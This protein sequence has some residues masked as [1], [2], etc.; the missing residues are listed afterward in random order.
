MK[1]GKGKDR[2]EDEGGV[3]RTM[4]RSSEVKRRTEIH[5]GNEGPGVDE[6]TAPGR[7]TDKEGTVG[8]LQNSVMPTLGF[9]SRCRKV[10]ES[11]SGRVSLPLL[12]DDHFPRGPPRTIGVSRS[13]G[14]VRGHVGPG[15]P[16][17]T[18]SFAPTV[19][20]SS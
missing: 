3:E 16:R 1:R 13:S 10:M 11:G 8:G 12:L 5:K 14:V 4:S 2:K 18:P 7:D 17:V 9:S 6:I 20:Q 19:R 15:L